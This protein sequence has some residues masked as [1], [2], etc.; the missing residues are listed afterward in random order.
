MRPRTARVTF[1]LRL[2]ESMR[3]ALEAA[4]RENDCSLNS[5]MV[6]RLESSLQAEPLGVLIDRLERILPM[7]EPAPV[8]TGIQSAWRELTDPEVQHKKAEY[9]AEVARRG[10]A[11][12]AAALRAYTLLQQE[13]AKLLY[14][15]PLVPGDAGYVGLRGPW[16]MRAWRSL[17]EKVD[18]L[19]A[20]AKV[21]GSDRAAERLRDYVLSIARQH[22]RAQFREYYSACLKAIRPPVEALKS[23]EAADIEEVRKRVALKPLQLDSEGSQPLPP[24]KH[25]PVQILPN[26]RTRVVDPSDPA[27]DGAVGDAK[28]GSER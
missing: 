6:R 4:A 17:V 7:Q 27:P 24:L 1:T 12:A 19:C 2:R 25:Q 21:A 8:K 14:G 20:T 23:D 5:E 18:Q 9:L 26:S 10:A 3:A 22:D 11:D 16:P 13:F 15:D 28:L